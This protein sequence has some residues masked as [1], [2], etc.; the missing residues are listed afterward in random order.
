M[1][2]VVRY[3]MRPLRYLPVVL[4]IPLGGS[5]VHTEEFGGRNENTSS[6][7]EPSSTWCSCDYR[8]R[9]GV[10]KPFIILIINKYQLT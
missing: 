5:L 4:L 8:D 10:T 7:K 1:E 6:T 9:K 2:V 3:G